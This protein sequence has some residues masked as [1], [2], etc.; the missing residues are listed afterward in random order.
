MYLAENVQKDEVA[1][2]VIS[3]AELSDSSNL[4]I[5]RN[6]KDI[7]KELDNP[8]MVRLYASNENKEH[9]YLAMELVKGG[10]LARLLREE[11]EF[12]NDVALFYAAES[13]LAL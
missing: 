3:K 11:G 9:L 6:E 4:E 1:M 5:I 13:V 7:L 8:F 12:P 10:D 2:K